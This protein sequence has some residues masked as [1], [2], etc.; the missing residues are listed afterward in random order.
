MP[1][2]KETILPLVEKLKQLND[3]E[4]IAGAIQSGVDFLTGHTYETPP[5][6]PTADL[7]RQMGHFISL[8]QIPDHWDDNDRLI[9]KLISPPLTWNECK[10]TFLTTIIPML[11]MPGTSSSIVLRFSYFTSYLQ[12]RGCT[13]EE[14]GS[15][16]I[17]YSRDGNNF[18]LSPL[19]F[20]PL[21]KFLQDL[22][23]SAEPHVI[24]AYVNT[25]RKK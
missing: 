12:Q 25:W 3:Y 9:L 15:L 8:L 6:F 22:I 21:R 17:S 23:K 11:D 13:P 14:I 18:D 5:V 24:D 16:M 10:E 1:Y 4:N 7:A 20:T 2:K 19:K